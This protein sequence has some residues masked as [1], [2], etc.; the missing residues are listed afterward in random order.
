MGRNTKHQMALK[1]GDK[2]FLAWFMSCVALGC[3]EFAITK[4]VK[5][6]PNFKN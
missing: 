2:D 6:S 5:K 3:K 1:D 4:I